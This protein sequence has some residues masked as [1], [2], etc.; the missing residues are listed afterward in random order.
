MGLFSSKKKTIVGTSVS[1]VLD[2]DSLVDTT[3]VSLIQAIYNNEDIPARILENM[4]GSIA[5]RA[6]RMY[7]HAEKNYVYGLPSGKML[8]AQEGTDEATLILQQIENQPIA[9]EYSHLAPANRLHVA[10]MRLIANH[11]Y[12]PQTNEITSLTAVKNKTVLLEDIHLEIPESILETLP[13]ETLSQW[14]HAAVSGF[15]PLRI[16]NQQD[17]SGIYVPTLIRRNTQAG[18][19]KQ[20]ARILYSWEDPNSFNLGENTPVYGVKPRLYD[21]F[22]IDLNDLDQDEDYLHVKYHVLDQTKYWMYKIGTGTYPVIDNL[23]NVPPDDSGTFFPFIFFR[24]EKKKHDASNFPEGYAANKKMSKIL[25]M[26]YDDMLDTIHENPDINDVQQAVLTFALPPLPESQIE[27]RYLYEFFSEQSLY[28]DVS[29]RE[30]SPQSMYLIN[31][32]MRRDKLKTRHAIVI[33]DK[34]FKMSLGFEAIYTRTRAGKIGDKGTY[35]CEFIQRREWEDYVDSYSGEQYKRPVD[36]PVY[37]YRY[38][39]SDVIYKEVEVVNLATEYLVAGTLTT[40]ADEND[41]TLLIPLDRSITENYSLQEREVLYSKSLHFVFNSLVVIKVKW[42]QSS[43]FKFVLTVVGIVLTIH[44]FPGTELGQA[45]LA[46]SIGMATLEVVLIAALTTLATTVLLS[47]AFKLFVKAV[48]AEAAFILAVVAVVSG[49]YQAW[50]HG[51][52]QGAPWAQELLQVASG[53]NSGI[54][55][56]VEDAIKDLLVD[57]SE[58]QKEVDEKLKLLESANDLLTPSKLLSPFTIFGEKPEEYYNRTVHSGNI[59]TL[60]IAAISNYVDLNL[61]LPK[62]SD[63]VGETFV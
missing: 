11:G 1:R 32:F 22:E 56:S 12:N 25:G 44:G 3:K 2:D 51:S 24:H 37:F 14:G 52:I 43:F 17:M 39:I 63:T 8:S 49:F 13:S 26:D 35:S 16:G 57:Q 33:Q 36:T 19:P 15:N 62:L 9:L 42:Y 5:I 30:S 50:D 4:Q 47:Y 54:S 61:T 29:V 58:F 20:I 6:D 34:L 23:F 46:S 38:Q 10:W 59:G 21:S 40:L 28:Q 41:K 55:A 53:L 60:G 18:P 27:K 7:R 31:R 45:L 48:G